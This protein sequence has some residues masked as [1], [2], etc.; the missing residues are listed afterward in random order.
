MSDA[1]EEAPSSL[2]KEAIDMDEAS[3]CPLDDLPI[4]SHCGILPGFAPVFAWVVYFL[5]QPVPIYWQSHRRHVWVAN[6]VYC[7][8]SQGPSGLLDRAID[9]AKEPGIFPVVR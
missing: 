7:S 2:D 1:V 5:Q 4:W 6:R 9:A 3:I 8:P